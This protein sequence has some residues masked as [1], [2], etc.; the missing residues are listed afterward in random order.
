MKIFDSLCLSKTLWMQFLKLSKDIASQY[1][2]FVQP[3]LN[4]ELSNNIKLR[5]SIGEFKA[6]DGLA[7]QCP[8]PR[9]R[10]NT[11]RPQQSTVH[12]DKPKSE[13]IACGTSHQVRECPATSVVFFKYNKAIFPVYV[14]LNLLQQVHPVPIGIQG[15]HGIAEVEA[16]EVVEAMVPNLLYMKLK[17][18]ILQNP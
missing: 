14:S 12:P 6:M 16:T 5:Q 8:T 1:I 3:D 18:L 11:R 9:S 13:C 2:N 10:S 17:H 15:D 7:R 4:S